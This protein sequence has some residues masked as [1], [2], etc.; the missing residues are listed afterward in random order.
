MHKHTGVIV[1]SITTVI[2][3][4]IST[5]IVQQ[6]FALK[7]LF[8]CITKASDDGKLTFKEYADCFNK[9][10]HKQLVAPVGFEN[11]T[12]SVTP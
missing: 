6:T 9:I 5:S 7:N 1:G 11:P 3:L 8:N 2:L 12:A 4:L 10:F